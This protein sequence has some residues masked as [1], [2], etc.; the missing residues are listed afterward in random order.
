MYKFINKNIP[1][2][3]FFF[4][5]FFFLFSLLQGD[6]RVWFYNA[7][8]EKYFQMKK[9]DQKRKTFLSLYYRWLRF[10]SKCSDVLSVRKMIILFFY[11]GFMMWVKMD[12]L[13]FIRV[14]TKNINF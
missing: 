13:I 11:F 7:S 14:S 2:L 10:V 9:I 12:K 8:S 1:R 5:S 6:V 4:F 3:T